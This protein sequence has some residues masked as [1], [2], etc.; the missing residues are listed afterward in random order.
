MIVLILLHVAGA[1][2][3]HLQ[4]HKHLMARMA[5]WIGPRQ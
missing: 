4:G 3:H 2:K 5:P 1:L